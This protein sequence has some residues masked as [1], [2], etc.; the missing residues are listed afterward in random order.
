MSETR[1]HRGLFVTFEGGD[2]AGKS[3]QLRA[4]AALL[5]E[6]GV[7]VVTTFEPGD[8]PAG[9]A[10]R[11]ILLDPG[12][13]PL[14]PRAELLLFCA[15]RAEHVD[16]V[17][18]PALERGAVVLCDRYTDSTLAYQGAGRRISRVDTERL[19]DWSTGGLVPDL[20]VLCDIS[21]AVLDTMPGRDRMES[22]GA[23][24]HCR[25]RAGFLDL[26]A[27]DPARFMVVQA[28]TRPAGE[29]AA[30]VA[31]AITARARTRRL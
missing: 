1:E 6:R 16:R 8:T 3:T 24:F 25:V 28:R 7:D 31:A 27:A 30:V 17:V 22:A 26:A 13:G 14:S 5:A 19:N 23:D 9:G 10:I 4:V 12:T 2:G 11:R 29:T 18:R 15:D 21:P 20:T